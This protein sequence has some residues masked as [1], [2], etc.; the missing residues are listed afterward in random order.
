MHFIWHDSNLNQN[1]EILKKYLTI[2]KCPNYYSINLLNLK[3]LIIILSILLKLIIYLN[4]FLLVYLSKLYEIIILPL[5][6]QNFKSF[7][8]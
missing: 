3:I 7:K 1:I 2:I 6:Y 4:T 8:H 5:I